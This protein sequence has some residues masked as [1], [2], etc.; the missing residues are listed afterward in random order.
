MGVGW[1]GFVVVDGANFFLYS[2]VFVV[3]DD[4]EV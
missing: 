3:S 1:I 2:G 4:N